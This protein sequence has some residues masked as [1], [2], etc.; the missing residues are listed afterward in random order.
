M[1]IEKINVG[2]FGK[3]QRK[4]IELKD[5]INVIEGKN[6]SGKTTYG[7][8]IK[9][10]FYGLT[11]H[12]KK[13][14][15]SWN[16]NDVSGS[17]VINTKK[18]RFRIE[19]S[20]IPH[21]D[22]YKDN[23]NIVD[24]SN[25]SVISGIKNAGEY[26]FSIPEE[27]FTKTVYIRQTDGAYFDGDGMGQAV[28][29]IFYSADESVNTEKALKKLD[30]ARVMIKHKK[31]TGRGMADR[32]EKERDEI[33]LRLAEARANNDLIL[34]SE[35]SLRNTNRSIEKNN[36]DLDVLEKQ[37]RLNEAESVIK[38]FDEQKAYHSKLA[39]LQNGRKEI[40][41]LA[42]VNGL[43]P[44]KAYCEGLEEVKTELLYL[45]KD[46]D[47]YEEDGDYFSSHEYSKETAEKIREYGGKT[48]IKEKLSGY[49]KTAKTSKGIFVLFLILSAV[50]ALL[51]VM[52]TKMLYILCAAF[53]VAAVFSVVNAIVA[54]SKK[55]ALLSFF[56]AENE[57]QLFAVV[58]KT[59][60]LEKDEIRAKELSLY[61]EKN[62]QA[63]ISKLKEGILKA[64]NTLQKWGVKENCADFVSAL[65]LIDRT[66]SRIGEINQSLALCDREIEKYNVLYG[67]A[68][69]Q[70]AAYNEAE[71]REKYSELS[72]TV[73]KADEIDIK[74]KYDFCTKAGNALKEKAAELE[75]SLA[76]YK[77]KTDTPIELESRLKAVNARIK[78]LEQKHKALILAHENLQNAALSLRGR[79]APELSQKAGRFMSVVTDGKYTEIG[80]S[81]GMKM[82]YTYEE[83]GSLHTREIE[84]L[85]FGTKD[86]AYV[87]LRLALAELFCKTGERLPV[88]F[89]E[90][91]VRADR[92]RLKNM[93]LL[94][95]GYSSESSQTVIFTSHTRENEILSEN[96][97][98]GSF[99]Y[100][101]L[102]NV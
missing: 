75:K 97:V 69:S 93:L 27:V 28:E 57:K 19:R 59:E 62:R 24:L 72:A 10:I 44:D 52:L 82:T 66:I 65:S 96:G 99:N 7:E 8:F 68:A 54:S 81:D 79:I 84:S 77:T 23:F 13:K 91:F 33:V 61:K 34:Q 92:G 41:E 25:N 64:E 102:E 29:N 98:F 76:V 56:G 67:V 86:M 31:N 101:N 74:K 43:Y 51:G 1:F 46:V 88:I 17:I 21:G 49:E 53:A 3:L 30:D 9:F 26:F 22:G 15:I 12:E 20:V 78:E 14:Y 18:G 73:T 80:V 39:A 47:K 89:D 87:S 36:R 100:I 94:A 85:S 35:A 90:A 83:N 40:V 50:S 48:G 95:K 38:K 60:E 63:A 71:L 37:M 16:T 32:L 11:P 70:T 5:G 45:K 42:T 4:E 6:E 2:S 55:R 58:A